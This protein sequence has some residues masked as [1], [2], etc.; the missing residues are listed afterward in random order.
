[1]IKY[2]AIAP[3]VCLI[4]MG[5]NQSCKETS[6]NMGLNKDSLKAV[7]INTDKTWSDLAQKI[8]FN[9]SRLNFIG[10]NAV[11]IGSGSM[12]LEGK[13]AIEDYCNSHPDSTIKIEWKA[14]R[15]EVAASG[16]IGYTF[17]GWTIRTKTKAKKDTIL[18]GNYVTIWHKQTD[19][20]W[21][22]ILDG[23]GDTPKP[24]TE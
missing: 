2:I 16:E 21:K 3:I 20:S 5:C 9:H 8:G 11:D 24:V 10:E 4:A 12:P 1:M 14:I 18:Y 7:L 22:Y 23:G 15:A 19:G 6:T 13:K 17:G